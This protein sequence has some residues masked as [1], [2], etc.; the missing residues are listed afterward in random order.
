MPLPSNLPV[1]IQALLTRDDML[2]PLPLTQAALEGVQ[3]HIVSN[4]GH[5]IHWDMP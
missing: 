1:P 2:I 5:S 4:A 3:T